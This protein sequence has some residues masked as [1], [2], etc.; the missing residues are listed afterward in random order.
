MTRSLLHRLTLLLSLLALLAAAPTAMASENAP[1]LPLQDED[2]D[3]DDG[4]DDDGDDDDDDRDEDDGDDE[5]DDRD[6]AE[7]D[8]DLELDRDRGTR[9][10]RDRAKERTRTKK[11]RKRA[12]REVVKGLYAKINIGPLFWF[13]S[14]KGDNVS[15]TGTSS[16]GTEMDFSLGYDIVDTLPFTLAVEASFFQVI[17]NGTGVSEDLNRDRIGL[18][19]AIQG[20][21]RI[22]GAIVAVR[23]GP[24]LGGKR[25]KRLNISGHAGG[26]VGYSPP[27]IDMQ[28]P[29]IAGRIASEYGGIMQGRPLGLIQGGV[30][31]E[32]YTKLSHFSI[33]LDLDFNVIIGDAAPLIGMGLATDIFVKYTF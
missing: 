32:Y 4:D 6:E 2:D 20:D 1:P 22:Y 9:G 27:L 7:D 14:I 16:T 15:H 29:T 28:S 33:G 11:K 8:D 3:D 23:A 17:T 31:V 30:G 10:S 5:D 18:P 19:S 13:G 12:T 25:V 24:N 21:F 26:G